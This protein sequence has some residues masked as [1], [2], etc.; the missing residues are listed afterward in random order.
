MKI[1]IGDIVGFEQG[2]FVH[3]RDI[4][5]NIHLDTE[6]V[7]HYNRRNIS[8]CACIKVDLRNA[9]DSVPWDFLR[10]ALIYFSFLDR[11]ID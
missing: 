7:K 1:V 2:D 8:P 4:I 3:G 5:N 9:F 10:N 11:F 6:M